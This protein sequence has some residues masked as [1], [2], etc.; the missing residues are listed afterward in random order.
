MSIVAWE[1]PS[2]GGSSMARPSRSRLARP[3]AL[4]LLGA[5]LAAPAPARATEKKI[6]ELD[7]VVKGMERL[8]G[9]LR[10]YREKQRI[11]AEVPRR[12]LEQPFIMA[13]SFSGGTMLAGWQWTEMLV[14]WERLDDKLVLVERNARYRAEPGQPIEDVVRRT[15]S[16]RVLKALPIIGE[17]TDRSPDRG[18][19]VDL[20]ALFADG[21]QVFFGGP[22]AA[23]DPA[24]AK[25]TKVKAFPQNVELAVTMPGRGDGQLT[26]LHYSLL[27]L[28]R[29]DYRPRKADDRVGYFL[30]AVTDFTGGRPEDDR[31]VRYVNRWDLR[32]ADPSLKISP[33]RKSIVFYIEKTVPIRFRRYVREGI[34]EWNKAFEKIGFT[35]AIVVRQQTD[36]NEFAAFDPEDARYNFF[37]WITS[38]RSFAMG[39]SRVN[40]L[41]GEILDADIIFDDSMVSSYLRQYD[42]MLREVPRT[43]LS[44]RMLEWY[45]LHPEEDPLAGTRLGLVGIAGPSAGAVA[46][47]EPGAADLGAA[48]LFRASPD[49]MR[50][51]CSLGEGVAHQLSFAALAAVAPKNGEWPEEF[52]GQV[53]KEVVMHEVGH[54]LGLRHNFHA[55]TWLPLGEINGEQ[56]PEA[57]VGSVMDYT[58]INVALEGK[59]QG[60]YQTTTIG[61]YD[62]WAIEYG[63]KPVEK[64]EEL[65]AITARVAEKGLDYA[66]DEDTTGSDPYVNRWDLGDD[67]LAYAEQRVALAKK[68]LPTIVDRVVPA[69]EGYQ[70]A[71]RAFDML[72]YDVAYAGGLAGRFVGGNEIRRDHKG[73]P[74]GRPPVKPVAAAK[75]R[76]ALRFVC[77]QIFGDATY[78]V[79]PELLRA[80]AAGRWAHWGSSDMDADLAYP[81]HERI[82][83][84]QRMA[85]AVIF[86]PETFERVEDQAMKVVPGEDALTLPELLGTVTDAIFAEWRAPAGKGA[87]T[88][89]GATAP[90]ALRPLI[91]TTRQ[92]LQRAYLGN[93]IRIAVHG[94]Y[95]AGPQVVRA[96]VWVKL[97]DLKARLDDMLSHERRG[98]LDPYTLAHLEESRARIAKALEASY[99]AE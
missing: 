37:R 7:E 73:D 47:G 54:T 51:Y 72:L 1:T 6:P 65:K 67:P 96:L 19:L 8:D 41:T 49:A 44:Q 59:S 25:F 56:K 70:R 86:N 99:R 28:P 69:G 92:N 24:L 88:Q 94:T 3:L 5:I 17:A 4:A 66:T 50:S 87:E 71:R 13:T 53:V 78:Q 52:I 29:S 32:K 84:V 31:F 34:L 63:Y 39:P 20:K 38:D 85:L 76:E 11:Y 2:T 30:T 58:P 22:G 79:S 95:G 33:P 77:D 75:Q 89:S 36:D 81:I 68:L 64:D 82:L 57:T 90:T 10:L 91:S 40:P 48:A 16:D 26:T 42:V 83:A 93:L 15:Y 23:L 61:P 12:E 14:A 60:E 97:K 21:A 9:V 35:D 98:A 45:G 62:Y 27:K 43:F 74:N 80:L 18:V 55:S 46:A